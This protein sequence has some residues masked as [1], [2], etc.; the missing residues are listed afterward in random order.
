MNVV[1]ASVDCARADSFTHRF[2]EVQKARGS[3]Y[4]TC[5]VQAPFTSP[6]HISMLSG[7]HPF[8]TG[9][10]WLVD[11]ETDGDVTLLPEVLAEEGYNTAAFTGG[12]PLPTGDM[13]ERFDTFEHVTTVDDRMEGRQE[14]GPANVLVSRALNWLDDHEGQDNFVFVHFFDLHLTLRSEFG[15]RYSP[16][17]D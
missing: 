15:S 5:I 13:D 1:L 7:M 6:S 12:Y 14:Y 16:E 2:F 3:Y 17:F 8:N 11:Y 10:R 4:D 9:V